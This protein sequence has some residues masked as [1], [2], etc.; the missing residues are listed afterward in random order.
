MSRS[1]VTGSTSIIVST[2]LADSKEFPL[3]FED[4]SSSLPLEIEINF[5]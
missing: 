1:K 3:I 4:I 2:R 5:T